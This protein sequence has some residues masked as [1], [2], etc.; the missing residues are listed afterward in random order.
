MVILNNN[1]NIKGVVNI[2]QVNW[3]ATDLQREL[4]KTKDYTSINQ[5][6]DKSI[7]YASYALKEENFYPDFIV[8]APSSSKFNHYYCTNLSRKIRY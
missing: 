1:I 2:I 8:A 5:F 6:I 4:S 7:M 3:N